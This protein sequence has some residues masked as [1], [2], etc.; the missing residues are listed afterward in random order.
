M[1]QLL[2][3]QLHGVDRIDSF[4]MIFNKC[5]NQL[6]ESNVKTDEKNIL[7]KDQIEFSVW[8]LNGVSKLHGYTENGTFVGS[9]NLRVILESRFINK[10]YF[11]NNII[12]VLRQL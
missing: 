5:L 6:N 3:E 1:I 8:L 7:P 12:L 4:W 9:S 2:V 11:S 10:N